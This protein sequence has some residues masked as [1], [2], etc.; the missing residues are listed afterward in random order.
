MNKSFVRATH[1][2]EKSFLRGKLKVQLNESFKKLYGFNGVYKGSYCAKLE[3]IITKF[4]PEY[5]KPFDEL[6]SDF[7]QISK[8]PWWKEERNTEVH[9]EAAKL[10]ALRHEKSMRARWLWKQCN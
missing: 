10:Y 8:E 7:E 4:F 2:Y 5:K 1:P 9:I 3:M 6:L